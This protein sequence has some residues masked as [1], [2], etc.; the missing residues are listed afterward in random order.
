MIIIYPATCLKTM[1]P[2]SFFRLTIPDN[3]FTLRNSTI[4]NI[5]NERMT[6]ENSTNCDI[7][8]A[9][10]SYDTA[11]FGAIISKDIRKSA[12]RYAKTSGQEARPYDP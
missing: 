9:S 4:I 10:Y 6:G 3:S 5:N 12:Y 1:K 8:A 2:T 11:P 7:V